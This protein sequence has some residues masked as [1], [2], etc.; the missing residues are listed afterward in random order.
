MCVASDTSASETLK[1]ARAGGLDARADGSG[2]L[3]GASA[4]EVAEL[5]RG[6]FDVDINAIEERAADFAAVF[7]GE[8]W[9]AGAGLGGVTEVA[10]GA[11]IHG[12]D[13][14]EARGEGE[15]AC[16]TGDGDEAIFKR[17][18]EDFKGAAGELGEFVEEEDAV[19][20]EGNFAGLDTDAAADQ[21]GI[22]DSVVGSAEGAG[23]DEG[24]VRRKQAANR[25]NAGCCDGLFQ[26]EVGH[27]SG[28][29]AREHGFA[30]ARRSDHEDIVAASDSDFGG[31]FGVV[32]ATDIGEI[33]IVG[34]GVTEDGIG[35]NDERFR[36][37]R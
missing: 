7:H 5:D 24:L 34:R 10:A 25:M 17:L 2:G 1:L 8:L 3:A 16:G 27:D 20:A 19:V 4:S 29:A 11:G 21:A 13:E 9:G 22:G 36:E 32:L 14:H 15:R 35:V 31:A 26:S 12:G 37:R 6:H 23:S 28:D 18:A 33:Y 30:G